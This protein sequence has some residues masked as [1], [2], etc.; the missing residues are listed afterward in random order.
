MYAMSAPAENA[1]SPSPVM[2]TTLVESSLSNSLNIFMISFATSM[3]MALSLS[4][5]LILIVQIPSDFETL[6][7]DMPQLQ[8]MR[9]LNLIGFILSPLMKGRCC[10]NPVSYVVVYWNVVLFNQA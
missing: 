9:K 1:L 10:S 7:R 6:T 2:T 4:G 8:T 3:F 5:L